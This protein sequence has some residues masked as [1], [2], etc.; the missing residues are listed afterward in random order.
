MTVRDGIGILEG[1]AALILQKLG[2]E[3]EKVGVAAGNG[4]ASR[5]G[6]AAG[7]RAIVN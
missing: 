7:K 4:A 3:N 6:A 2:A 1:A 5:V